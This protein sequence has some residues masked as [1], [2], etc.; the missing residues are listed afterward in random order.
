MNRI[1]LSFLSATCLAF[2]FFGCVEAGGGGGGDGDGGSMSANGLSCGAAACGGDIVGT[3]T[4]E[5]WC[6]ELPEFPPSEMCPSA[7]V[8]IDIA[9]AGT[10]TINADE[11]F[12]RAID[13]TT[14]GSMTLP[15]ECLE[16]ASCEELHAYF[17]MEE[18]SPVSR[19]ESADND[20]CRCTY[21]ETVS[22]DEVSG[23]YTVDGN[24]V[25]LND[26][27]TEE[28]V[29]FCVGGNSIHLAPS[30]SEISFLFNKN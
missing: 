20:G 23:T 11:S 12:T 29:D 26:G 5:T 18:E 15:A 17:M 9:M 13:T 8:E 14:N 30:Q 25:T 27:E 16:M 24:T 19:C 7:V 10:L 3:W 28:T 2:V 22:T 6:G 4:L 1:R 21:K